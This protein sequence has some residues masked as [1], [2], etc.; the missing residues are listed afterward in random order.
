MDHPS[1]AA[2]PKSHAYH[3]N[4]NCPDDPNYHIPMPKADGGMR[5][6]CILRA[7]CQKIENFRLITTPEFR[8]DCFRGKTDGIPHL[9]HPSVL[10][11][12][13]SAKAW[14]EKFSKA[15]ER[16][17]GHVPEQAICFVDGMPLLVPFQDSHM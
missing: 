14:M 17:I 3:W 13:M 7:T 5:E 4:F 9:P 15:A 1:E 2:W 8:D 11:D 12:H 6:G 10:A 16:N